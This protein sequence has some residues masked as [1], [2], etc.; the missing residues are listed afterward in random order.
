MDLQEHLTQRQLDRD[1]LIKGMLE[2]FD[3]DPD[4]NCMG[5]SAP[6]RLERA[7]TIAD[8]AGLAVPKLREIHSQA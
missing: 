1:A 4:H 6:A 3:G 8:E 5:R 7:L 2:A